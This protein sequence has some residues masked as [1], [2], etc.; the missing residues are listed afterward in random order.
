MIA[1]LF[2]RLQ[3]L[4]SLLHMSGLLNETGWS[5]GGFKIW[6]IL[7]FLAVLNTSPKTLFIVLGCKD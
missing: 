1:I 5:L 6:G 3:G 4:S 2:P 7:N